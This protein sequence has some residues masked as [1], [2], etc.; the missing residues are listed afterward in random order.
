MRKNSVKNRRINDEVMKALSE[1][2]R[3]DLKDPRISPLTSVVAVNVAPDL[4]TCKAWIS[5]YGDAD[6]GRRTM[7]G[8]RSASGFIR[9]ELARRVNLRNTPELTFLFDDSIAYGVAMSKKI[10]E[11]AEKDRLAQE[12]RG[13][14]ISE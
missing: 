14:E 9:G 1:I 7:E 11:V 2:I 12:Q 13:E 6:A 4:K 3:G 5:V 10:D 8:I